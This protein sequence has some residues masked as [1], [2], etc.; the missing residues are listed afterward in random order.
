MLFATSAIQ[1][2]EATLFLIARFVTHGSGM[3]E[4]ENRFLSAL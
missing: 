3:S 1:G 4:A 2:D